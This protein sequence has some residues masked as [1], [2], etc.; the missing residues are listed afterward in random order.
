MEV[1]NRKQKICTTWRTERF[2]GEKGV[3]IKYSDLK[4]EPCDVNCELVNTN[5]IVHDDKLLEISLHLNKLP[6]VI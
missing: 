2:A 5:D 6:R 1:K 3:A 4:N